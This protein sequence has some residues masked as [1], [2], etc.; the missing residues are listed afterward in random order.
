MF[1]APPYIYYC[2]CNLEETKINPYL[3]SYCTILA[4]HI[5]MLLF[6]FEWMPLGLRQTIYFILITQVAVNTILHYSFCRKGA[7]APFA[8][9]LMWTSCILP[10]YIYC[11]HITSEVRTLLHGVV[12]FTFLGFCTL[13]PVIVIST[14]TASGYSLMQIIGKNRKE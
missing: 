9:P 6:Y 14:L 4:T 8:L 11:F 13:L 12:F 2:L 5:T 10:L 1:A 3:M 7:V